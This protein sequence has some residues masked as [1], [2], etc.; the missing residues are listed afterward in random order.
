MSEKTQ[1]MM[2]ELTQKA[3]TVR[4]ELIDLEQK[5][6]LK[7]EEFFRIQGAME[8]IQEMASDSDS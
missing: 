5:F 2:Q 7:K 6:N 8:A 1:S 4:N 3:E